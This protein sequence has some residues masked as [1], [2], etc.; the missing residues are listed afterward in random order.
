MINKVE[1]KQRL[2]KRRHF[3]P[4]ALTL[5]NMF[6]GFLC[7]IYASSGRFEKAIAAIAVAILLDGL[8]GRVARRLNATSKFGIEF[9]SFS[10]LV[11]FGIAPAILIYNWAFRLLADE[12]GVFVCF[13]YALCAAS[14]LAKFN[15]SEP[16]VK[17]FIGMP[18]PGAAGLVAASVYL[19][20]AAEAS[21]SLVMSCSVLMLGLAYL[22]VSPF[23]FWK[24]KLHRRLGLSAMGSLG[25]GALM[26]LIW[27]YNRLGLFILALVYALSGPVSVLYS[28]LRK[29]NSVG[30]EPQVAVTSKPSV[31]NTQELK[32]LK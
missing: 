31:E 22:M 5:G 14:R 21:F 6:C 27:Y 16:N 32:R 29:K 28:K 3:V 13:L 12:F 7:I 4:N 17:G 15:I 9:D 10:D 1:I 8:D 23:P 30:E 19:S 18:T 24:V 25:I 2:Y 11:S 20:P 26:A